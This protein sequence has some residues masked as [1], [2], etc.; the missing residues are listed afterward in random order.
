MDLQKLKGLL[1]QN[2]YSKKKLAEELNVSAVAVYKKLQGKLPFKLVE[3]E[4]ICK[5]FDVSINYFF[6]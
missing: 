4:K 6:E 2:D 1:A 5:I 3:L